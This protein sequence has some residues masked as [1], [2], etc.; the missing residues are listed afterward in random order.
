ML[1]GAVLVPLDYKLTGSE[2]LALLEHSEAEVLIGDYE[3]L[4][5]LPAPPRVRSV[6]VVGLPERESLGA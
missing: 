6:L 1:R 2:H 5:A 4:R 3:Y